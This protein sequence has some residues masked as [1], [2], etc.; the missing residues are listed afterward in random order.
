MCVGSLCL[1]FFS[2]H[3]RQAR[4][5]SLTCRAAIL[6]TAGQLSKQRLGGPSRQPSKRALRSRLFLHPFH[7]SAPSVQISCSLLSRPLHCKMALLPI[8][9]HP[10]SGARAHRDLLHI[11]FCLVLRRVARCERNQAAHSLGGDLSSCPHPQPQADACQWFTM[12][13]KFPLRGHLKMHGGYG[14]C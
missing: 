9:P 1:G 6:P 3:F 12:G 14:C 5:T 13:Y 7:Q 8:Y 2:E 11:F 4:I 10:P